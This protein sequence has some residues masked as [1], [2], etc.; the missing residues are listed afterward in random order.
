MNSNYLKA[1]L[2]KKWEEMQRG[3]GGERKSE[4]WT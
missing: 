3:K 4:V 2:K 1:R